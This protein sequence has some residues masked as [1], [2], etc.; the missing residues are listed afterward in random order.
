MKRIFIST[1]VE[2][3]DE[4]GERRD[5]VSQEWSH[6]LHACGLL[7]VFLPNHLP[8]ILRIGKE[9]PMD[10]ILLT[11]GNDLVCC[12]GN[13]PERDEVEAYLLEQAQDKKI[14]LLGVCRGMQMIL[15]AF[16]ASLCKVQNHT[17]VEHPLQGSGRVVNSFHNWG[18]Y[19]GGTLE[20]L[21]FAED[22]VIEAARHPAL[23]ITGIMWHPERYHPFRDEDL[24][25]FK[26]V[27][28]A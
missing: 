2:V 28:E 13:A 20:P 3:L 19:D 25:F 5:A 8:S 18:A 27:F 10:G 7:P 26:R 21:E 24:L 1:R 4:I 14:P 22:G 9:I 17:R 12:G 16:G 6:L 15:K 23:P 11:G